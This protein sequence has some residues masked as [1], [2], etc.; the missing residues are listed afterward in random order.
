MAA[1]RKAAEK[2]P[3]LEPAWI[4]SVGDMVS[5]LRTR[6]E[7]LDLKEKPVKARLHRRAIT[8]FRAVK[9][10]E[11]MVFYATVYTECGQTAR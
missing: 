1:I 10:I 3:D 7:R 9:K 11:H 6:F 2:Y 8:E 5:M 4:Q